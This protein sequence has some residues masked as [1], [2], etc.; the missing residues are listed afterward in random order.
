[1]K[2]VVPEW[3][4]AEIR[5]HLNT[6]LLRKNEEVNLDIQH[7]SG[8]EK[9]RLS[10]A[11]IAAKPPQLLILDEITNNIDLE[12][13]THLSQILSQYPGAMLIVCHEIKFLDSLPID[14]TYIIQNKMLI[15]D[16]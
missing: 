2:Q 13:K 9:V 14:Q 6:F 3:S 7:L 15:L 5:N 8:G 11:L 16:K 12:T 4:Y 10:L 1:M